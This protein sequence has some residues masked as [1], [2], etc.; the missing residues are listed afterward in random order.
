MEKKYELIKTDTI[1]AY[2]RT[3]F[4]VRYLCDIENIVAAGDIGGYIE[5]E[6]NL[7]QQGNSVVLGDAEVYGNAKVCGDAKVYGNAKVCGDAMVFGNAKVCGDAKV[8][9]N[10]KVCGDA[11]VFGN[12][13]VY[14]NAKVF[15]DAMV[16][17]NAKV[18]G[19]AKVFGDAEVCG[20]AKVYGNAKVC[21]DAEVYGNA[22]VCGDAKVQSTRDYIVFK[23][24]WSSGRHFTWTRSDNKWTVGCFYGTGEELIAKAYKDSQMKGR[25]YER[26]VRY[27]ESIL[28]D[29]KADRK[30]L[31]KHT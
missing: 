31:T 14:G 15:G 20:D 10:A 13:K 4:R 3:L 18:Y 28:E 5:G 1:C 19:N 21:G 12:A 7:S 16:F 8:Y 27:V 11:M 2:G 29:E 22:E 30:E 23:N 25:E 24:F 17:G 9:G 26:V 6:Y